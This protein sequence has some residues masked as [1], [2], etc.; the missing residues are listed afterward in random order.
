MKTVILAAGIASRLRPLTDTTPKCLLKIGKKRILEMT[1]E[2]LLE[3]NNSEIIIVTGYR[4]K[5]IREF[6]AHRFPDLNVTYIYNSLY[7]STNNIY[8]L[9]LTKD[10]VLGD[11]MMMMDSDIVFDK[12]IITKLVNS[13]YENCLAL[14]RHEVHDE[15][16]KVKV[17]PSSRVMEISKEVDP[18]QAA[19]E[20][21]GI[22][23]FRGKSLYELFRI[24]EKKVVGEKK[25]NQF[26]ETAFEELS[27]LYT[28]DTTEFFCMEIDTAEDLA[29][30]EGLVLNHNS[31]K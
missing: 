27:D 11:D 7:E 12:S 15:E 5:M 3:T 14:K 8:S 24:I 26:Y 1:I 25:V 22:E 30:A 29:S 2:N 23:L 18:T 19:G 4:E 28:V 31:Q 9:W 13:G 6:V 10:S 21:I 16:I 20:S 17:D